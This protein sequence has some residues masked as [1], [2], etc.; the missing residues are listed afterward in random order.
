MSLFK[1]TMNTLFIKSICCS[2]I[3]LLSLC[4]FGQEISQNSILEVTA[5]ATLSVIP[6]QSQVSIYIKTENKNIGETVDEMDK[7]TKEIIQRIKKIGFSKED[8]KTTNY[9]LREKTIY[10]EKKRIKDGYIASQHIELTFPYDAKRLDK[11]LYS[12]SESKERAN[13]NFSFTISEERKQKAKDELL[14]LSIIEAKRKAQIMA[15]SA[16]VSLGKIVR[17][18]YHKDHNTNYP[19]PYFRSNSVEQLNADKSSFS[20]MSL[21]EINM[22]DKISIQWKIQ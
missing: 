7:Q 14:R 12:F 10:K 16:E 21:K 2:L 19:K 13:L 11:L 8:I 3:A 18:S 5:D 1:E 4:C 22:S 15:N 20:E 17:I 9:N 6:D